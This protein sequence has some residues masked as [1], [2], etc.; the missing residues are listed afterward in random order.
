VLDVRRA[1]DLLPVQRRIQL[2]TLPLSDPLT[3]TCQH[4]CPW[5]VTEPPFAPA[6]EGG[7]TLV[8]YARFA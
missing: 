5:C 6:A 3:F 1:H 4:A 7:L 8:R 2:S